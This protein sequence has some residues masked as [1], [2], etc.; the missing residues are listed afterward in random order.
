MSESKTKENKKKKVWF[1][2]DVE[3]PS[4]AGVMCTNDGNTFY[5][6]TKN[7]W[8]RDS[9]ASCHITND[10]TGLYNI[11]DNNE[12]IPGSSSIMPAKK[13]SSYKSRCGKS[14][15]LNRSIL[16]GL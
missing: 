7:I 2:E 8:I 15:E 10:N 3:Q 1:M 4:E 11:I 5:S 13:K 12:L 9:G 14:M 16:Y 6:F